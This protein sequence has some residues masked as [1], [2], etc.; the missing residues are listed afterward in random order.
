MQK[1]AEKDM[2]KVKKIESGIVID[3]VPQGRAVKLLSILGIDETFKATI[4]VL[5]NVPSAT[6]GLK[7]IIKIEGRDLKK[8]ELEKIALIAPYATIN[9][10][11]DFEVIEKYKVKLPDLLEGV[12]PCPNPNCIT[13]REGISRLHVKERN[14]L[15]LQCNYCE[16]VYGEAEFKF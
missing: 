13:N 14:P 15:K 3:H 16:K 8:K 10:I 9:V 12:V 5:I 7:D 11:K 2:L 4:S 6:S 1:N